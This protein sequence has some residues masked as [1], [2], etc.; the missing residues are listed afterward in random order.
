[1]NN[2]KRIPEFVGYVNSADLDSFVEFITCPRYETGHWLC[3]PTGARIV[4]SATSTMRYVR[5]AVHLVFYLRDGF[6]VSLLF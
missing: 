5:D 3:A 4:A 1:M 6:T 2:F